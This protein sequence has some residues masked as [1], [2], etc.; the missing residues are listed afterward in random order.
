MG[1]L[2]SKPSWNGQTWEYKAVGSAGVGLTEKKLN[3]IG[4]DGWEL[5]GINHES[6]AGLDDVEYIF[7]RPAPNE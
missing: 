4:S 2:S 5:V 3:K 7:K 1:I 6:E